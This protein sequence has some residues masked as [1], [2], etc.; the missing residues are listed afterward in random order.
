MIVDVHTHYY[1][2]GYLEVLKKSEKFK[3][4][5]DSSGRSF[6]QAQGARIV[7]LTSPMTDICER[8][9]AMDDDGVDVAVISLSTPNIFFAEKSMAL[10]LCQEA[11]NDLLRLSQ[12][13]SRRIVAL[14]SVPLQ[15]PEL[16]VKEMERA[17]GLG[18]VGVTIGTNINGQP[19]NLEEF[20]PFYEA[21]DALECAIFVHPMTPAGVSLMY[22]YAL[23]PL[24]G[25]VFDTTLTAARLA[26]S[27]FFVKYPR[28]KLILAHLGGAVP[29]LWE[30]LNNGYFAYEE[31][32]RNI[33]ERPTEYLRRVYYDTVSFHEP[34]LMCAYKTVGADHL[35]MGSDY[36]H[37]I[38]NQKQAV[39]SLKELS[40]PEPEKRKILGGNAADIFKIAP[41]A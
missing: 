41:R 14:S 27:G 24:V 11:N 4:G 28:I 21:A 13:H 33:T 23:G 35:L 37:V 22:E 7:T 38:G 15:Y 32:R 19:L 25:F 18:M 2:E 3:I 40:I 1:P 12:V 30:R 16:A 9:K 20:A 26:Y 8:I 5:T 36:P 31:C 17:L 29:Y 39:I 6:I 34:A 10:D